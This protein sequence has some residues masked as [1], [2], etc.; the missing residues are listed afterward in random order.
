MKKLVGLVLVISLY[1]CGRLRKCELTVAKFDLGES[2]SE[3]LD[4]SFCGFQPNYFQLEISGKLEGK[5][6]LQEFYKFSGNGLI[7]TLIKSDY[8]AQE[9][10]FNYRPLGEVKGDL[11]FKISLY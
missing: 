7:D 9:F 1:G 8:Y 5:I 3:N 4:F 6:L 2:Y 10:L 11:E